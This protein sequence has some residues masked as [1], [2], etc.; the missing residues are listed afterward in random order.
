MSE[1]CYDLEG[2]PS[3]NLQ[4]DL[5]RLRRIR[6]GITVNSPETRRL[7]GDLCQEIREIETELRTR[8]D[9]S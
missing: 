6:A 7:R 5:E 8:E 9:A 3:W 2:T 4:V 1:S